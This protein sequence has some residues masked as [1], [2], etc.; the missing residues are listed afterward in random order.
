MENWIYDEDLKCSEAF[1]KTLKQII[2]EHDL[3]NEL[4]SQEILST[5]VFYN[6]DSSKASFLVAPENLQLIA[7]AAEHEFQDMRIMNLGHDWHGLDRYICSSAISM[8]DM[9][10]HSLIKSYKQ[11]ELD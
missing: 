3:T 10:L 8:I 7:F 6:A 5:H 2:D 9:P 1:E 4:I 11:L